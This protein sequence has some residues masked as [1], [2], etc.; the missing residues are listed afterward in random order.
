VSPDYTLVLR[1]VYDEFLEAIQRV[2]KS[3]WPNGALA[4]DTKWGK[5]VSERH[6]QRLLNMLNKT[7]GKI[8]LGG[9]H[10]RIEDGGVR[11]EPTIVKD[12]GL[13]DV[14]MSE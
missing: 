4:P 9:K 6:A 5:I 10:E 14:L 12:V 3:F 7:Q 1:S 13:D 11:I 2:Y 8:F